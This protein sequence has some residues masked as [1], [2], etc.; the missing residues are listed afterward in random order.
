MPYVAMVYNPVPEL[1]EGK[2]SVP[3]AAQGHNTG[4]VRGYLSGLYDL[5][6]LGLQLRKN[7]PAK[8]G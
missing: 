8:W 2:Q 7:K 4:A 5:D 1:P 3:T 6:E